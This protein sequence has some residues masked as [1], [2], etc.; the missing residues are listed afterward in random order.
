LSHPPA[1]FAPIILG[2][3]VPHFVQASQD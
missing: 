3:T 1:L 2:D